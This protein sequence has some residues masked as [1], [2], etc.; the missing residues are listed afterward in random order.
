MSTQL[1]SLIKELQS[2]YHQISDNRKTILQALANT[3]KVQW[4]ENKPANINFICTH[5]SRRSQLAEMWMRTTAEV[6]GLKNLNSFSGGTEGTAF[7]HRMVKA[8][9]SFGFALDMIE[10]GDNPIYISE[11]HKM[12]SKKYEDPFNPST[13]FIAVMVCDHAD[14]NC[15]IVFGADARISL[16][17]IDP[18]ESDDTPNENQVYEAKV[19]EV[20]REILYVGHLLK[21]KATESHLNAPH[22]AIKRNIKVVAFDADDTLWVNETY[23]HEAEHRFQELMKPYLPDYET[24]K[25]LLNIERENLNVYGYGIKS[26]MLSMIEAGMKISN[27]QIDL[28]TIKEIIAIGKEQLQKPVEIL[29]NVESVLKALKGKYKLILATKGDLH[30]QERKIEKS[31]IAHYFDYVE[32]LSEKNEA[33]YTKLL[34]HIGVSPEQFV[35]I[36]NSVKSDILPILALGGHAIHIPFYVTWGLEQVDKKV[37]HENFLQLDHIKQVLDYIS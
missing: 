32:V 19:K 28:E 14:Q 36:G 11:G 35:M 29:E 24:A 5:N 26:F 17:Y 34:E 30:D 16:P 3:I 12:F 23:F 2:T 22:W 25:Y 1:R 37:E 15:P 7:N 8:V 18:K 10:D 6:Y 33:H 13:D 27:D 4:R 20:G 31:G 21:K 9:Q